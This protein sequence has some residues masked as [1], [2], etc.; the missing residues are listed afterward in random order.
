M[1]GAAKL[2]ECSLKQGV[3]LPLEEYHH[4]VSQRDGD[5][6]FLIAPHGP[7]LQRAL[8]TAR[9]GRTWGGTVYGVI[10]RGERVL[11]ESVDEVIALPA[12]H[13]FLAPLVY[14]IPGQLFAYH[15]G[16]SQFLSLPS[17]P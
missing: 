15:V 10:T 11:E 16:M 6:L 14:S 2:K 7:T 5:P 12:M 9:S 4:Y 3:A 1:L 8:D 13:E 17:K